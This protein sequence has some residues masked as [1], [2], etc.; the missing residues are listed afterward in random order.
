MLE[1]PEEVLPNAPL[2]ARPP[3]SAEVVEIGLRAAQ[4]RQPQW[5]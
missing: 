4:S 2:I 1:P 5:S 3:K